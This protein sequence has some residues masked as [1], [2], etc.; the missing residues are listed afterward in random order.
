MIFPRS[1]DSAVWWLIEMSCDRTR[2]DPW[3]SLR[4]PLNT[5]KW[6]CRRE[7]FLINF[8]TI[9]MISTVLEEMIR[10]RDVGTR[11]FILACALFFLLFNIW[12]TFWRNSSHQH[13]FVSL[14][15]QRWLLREEWEQHITDWF[16]MVHSFRSDRFGSL[17]LNGISSTERTKERR[18]VWQ[19]RRSGR[20]ISFYQLSW[21]TVEPFHYQFIGRFAHIF[22]EM[23][24]RGPSACLWCGSWIRRFYSGERT[25]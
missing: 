6:N 14:R 8:L 17:S 2:T 7:V 19:H 9:K 22:K 12:L 11:S 13:V 25:L 15:I 1:H 16:H 24:R 18:G 23:V 21:Q 4:I 20:A 5:L 10:I 3:C